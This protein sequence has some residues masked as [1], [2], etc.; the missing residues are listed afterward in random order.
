MTKLVFNFLLVICLFTAACNG[1][2]IGNGWAES[3][4]RSFIQEGEGEDDIPA[5]NDP[6]FTIANDVKYLTDTSTVLGIYHDGVVKAYPLAIL[7]WHEIVN[8]I[9]GE[10]PIAITYSTLSGSGVAFERVSNNG[11]VYEMG[12]SGLLYNS[13]LIAS[14]GVSGTYWLQLLGLGVKG[15]RINQELKEFPLIEMK[16]ATWR[17]LFPNSEVLNTSTGFN[18]PYKTYP[19]GDYRTNDTKLLFDLTISLDSLDRPIPFKEK[20]LA[21]VISADT[22]IYPMSAFPETGVK[23][24]EEEISGQSVLIVGSREHQMIKA[25]DRKRSD[26]SIASFQI[27]DTSSLVLIDEKG[28][29]YDILGR[30]NGVG[31]VDNLSPMDAKL[32]YWFNWSVWSYPNKLPIYQ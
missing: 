22:M 27:A 32:A 14:D 16:W 25:F 18:R 15:I 19:Y 11:F 28:M 23:L 31:S 5:I 24:V 30:S 3:I 8:D 10:T 29:E 20:A 9:V 26:G 6:K 17:L 13:N 2:R 1:G 4:D 21:L 12:V 7:H